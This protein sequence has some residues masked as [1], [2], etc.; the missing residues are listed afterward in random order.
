MPVGP[1][2]Q[3]T[4]EV[5]ARFYGRFAPGQAVPC[6]V[7]SLGHGTINGRVLRVAAWFHA[8]SLPSARGAAPTTAL[9][10]E[11]VF[12]LTVALDF[13][14]AQGERVPPGAT[15]SIDL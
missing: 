3:F 15:A 11:K 4:V 2:R 8:P 6:L 10:T 7:P 12:G 9:G 13:D 14:D 1:A 5:P